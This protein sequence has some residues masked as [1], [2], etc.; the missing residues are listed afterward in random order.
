MNEEIEDDSLMLF[1]IYWRGSAER[2][3]FTL[4]DLI[5]IIVRPEKGLCMT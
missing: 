2:S 3:Y 1:I 5:A 4:M